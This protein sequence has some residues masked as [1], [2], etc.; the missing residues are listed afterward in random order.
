MANFIRTKHY[1]Y[2]CLGKRQKSKRKYRRP[3]GRHNK[4]RQKWKGRTPMVE[5]GYKNSESIRGLIQGKMPL[6]VSNLTELAKVGKDNVIILA[7]VG[8]RNKLEI[9]KEAKAKKIT[10]LNLN[11]DRFLRQMNKKLSKFK[12]ETINGDK[13]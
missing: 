8:K 5:V 4:M 2:A 10:I 13:K 9:V 6:L 1:A 12:K 11:S 3:S 7:K